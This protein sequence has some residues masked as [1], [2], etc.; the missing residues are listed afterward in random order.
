MIIELEFICR[1]SSLT[2]RCISS[3][4]A[5][6][7][8][9]CLR[10]LARSCVLEEMCVCVCICV[11][12]RM[13]VINSAAHFHFDCYFNLKYNA[14]SFGSSKKGRDHPLQPKNRSTRHQ[15]FT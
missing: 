12:T 14:T 11:C 3:T 5:S 10:N 7:T 1:L 8:R 15:L 6:K 2:H 9:Q 13:N 4:S